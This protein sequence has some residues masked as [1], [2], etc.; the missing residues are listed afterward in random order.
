[1]S[2]GHPLAKALATWMQTAAEVTV[3]AAKGTG[4]NVALLHRDHVR[5]SPHFS[6][7]GGAEMA[8][9]LV[10][11]MSGLQARL[12]SHCD[13]TAEALNEPYAVNAVSVPGF[14][15]YPFSI[16]SIILLPACRSLTMV[17]AKNAKTPEIIVKSEEQQHSWSGT[18]SFYCFNQYRPEAKLRIKL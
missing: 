18:P 3:D 6:G 16:F 13:V 8:F 5:F 10:Q 7:M 12:T 17:P 11:R 4:A 1:M 2:E 9:H 14:F 15:N